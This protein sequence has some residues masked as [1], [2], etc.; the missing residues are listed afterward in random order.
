MG[1]KKRNSQSQ[2]QADEAAK[3]A[4]LETGE[5]FLVKKY[6]PA[7]SYDAMEAF[8]KYTKT[9]RMLDATYV[10]WRTGVTA[11]KPFVF[12][13]R[14][15]GVDLGWGRGK[16]REAAMDCACR[17]AFSLVAAHGYNKWVRSFYC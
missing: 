5:S 9:H 16:T 3:K 6:R 10:R 4:K 15:G 2:H 14:V 17:A 8:V 13:A 11:E 12:S 7:K 1:R